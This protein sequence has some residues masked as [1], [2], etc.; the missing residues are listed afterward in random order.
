MKRRILCLLLSALLLLSMLPELPQPAYAYETGSTAAV[1]TAATGL[2]HV[3]V[4]DREGVLWTWGDNQYGQLGNGT[5]NVSRTTTPVRIMDGVISVSCGPDFTAAIKSDGSLWMW[6]MNLNGQLGNGRSGDVIEGRTVVQTTP[7]Q[8]MSDVAAVSCGNGYTA[9]IKT[10]GSLWTWGV[11]E[12]GQLGSGGAYDYILDWGAPKSPLQTVPRKIMD[13]VACVSCGLG[14]TAAV[15]TDGTLW[16]WGDTGVWVDSRDPSRRI[17]NFG[18]FI[19]NGGEGNDRDGSLLIQTVP[20]QIMDGVRTVSCGYGHGAAVKTDGSLWVWGQNAQGNFGNGTQENSL[21]PIR[22]TDGVSSVNCY[23][24]TTAFIKTDGSLWTCGDNSSSQLG[25]GTNDR[26]FEPVKVLDQVVSVCAGGDNSV[27]MLAVRADETLW[28]WGI[29]GR[30]LDNLGICR[31]PVLVM[32]GVKLPLQP[33]FSAPAEPGAPKRY[34]NISFRYYSEDDKS[35]PMTCGGL[36]FDDNWLL[37]DPYQYNH[38]LATFCLAMDMAAME[39]AERDYALSPKDANI[40]ALLGQ[41]GYATSGDAYLCAGYG[42]S[43]DP[44]GTIGMVVSQKVVNGVTCVVIVLRGGGYGGGGWAGD[45]DVGSQ[46]VYHHGFAAAADDA[47][48]RIRDYMQSQVGTGSYR[49]L[50]TGYSRSAATANLLSVFLRNIGC[51]GDAIHTYTFATPNNQMNV[52]AD[53]AYRNIFNILNPNDIVPQVPLAAWGF[54]KAGISLKLPGPDNEHDEAFRAKFRTLTRSTD[55][56]DYYRQEALVEEFLG[57]VADVIPDRKQYANHFEQIMMRIMQGDVSWI[58]GMILCNQTSCSEL[59][60]LLRFEG[61]SLAGKAKDIGTALNKIEL[62]LDTRKEQYGADDPYV[63]LLGLLAQMLSEWI[64]QY[65][66]AA[67][68]KDPKVTSVADMG[69][70]TLYNILVKK[71][72]SRVLLQHWPAVYLAWMLSCDAADLNAPLCFSDVAAGAYYAEAVYW[73]LDREITNGTTAETFSPEQKC[74]RAQ[75]LTFLWRAAGSPM[76]DRTI[77]FSDVPPGSYYELSAKWAAENGMTEAGTLDPDAPCTRGMAV[78]FMWKYAGSS[79][80]PRASFRDVPETASY[81]KAVDWAYSTG[82]VNGTSADTFSP[83][84]VCTRGQIVTL[85]YRAFA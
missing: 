26:R 68:G 47:R 46:G 49:I 63:N 17:A 42:A 72:E 59:K 19:G 62:V 4:V 81:A 31:T 29:G 12:V 14:I 15:K 44:D 1:T 58:D 5:T 2:Y 41:I 64:E 54:G 16:T 11:N 82:I 43:D 8:V 10:D 48:N 36:T 57:R 83:E 66:S 45:F 6:G 27:R 70:Q 30:L 55:Y 24:Y 39:L 67:L 76:P 33:E 40:K 38:G 53:A 21:Y 50:L 32:E 56:A 20:V 79:A 75:I 18:C 3:A 9:A 35:A 73:A 74:T 65:R 28:G 37:G 13:G 60:E 61:K 69:L 52:A 51:P 77:Y 23:N 84:Q 22:I 34:E 71:E 78:E 25:D 85:L 7:V 80:A